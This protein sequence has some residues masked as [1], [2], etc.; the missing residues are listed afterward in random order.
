MTETVLACPECDSADNIFRRNPGKASTLGERETK[1]RCS[2]CATEFDEPVRRPAK[3]STPPI[4]GPA[5]RLLEANADDV[6]GAD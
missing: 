6:L 1:W 5:A 3:G 2:D 4:T